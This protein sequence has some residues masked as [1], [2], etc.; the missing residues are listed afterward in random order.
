MA[1][2]YRFRGS[3]HHHGPVTTP[4]T[5]PVTVERTARYSD[6]DPTR[7]LGREGERQRR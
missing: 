6:L 7:R 5:F 1:A 4:H 3:V 2:P